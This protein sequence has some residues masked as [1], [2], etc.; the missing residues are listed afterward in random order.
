MFGVAMRRIR[1]RHQVGLLRARGHPGG[2]AAPLDIEEHRGDIG[3]VRESD[4]LLHERDAGARRVGE[5]TGTRP[6]GTDDDA[7]GGQFIFG[8]QNGVVVHA[9]LFVHAELLAECLELLH[10]RRGRR[11]GIPGAHGRAGI[12]RT[13]C[14]GR[15][16]IDEDRIAGGIHLLEME[17]QG[18][19]EVR[20][21]VV[22]AKPNGL[23]I[24]VEEF[25]L[26]AVLLGQHAAHHIHVNV[27]QRGECAGVHDV[28]QQGA[29]AIALEVLHAQAPERDAEDRDAL[30]HE[31]RLERP[32]RVVHEE[33]AGAH[34]GH[35][36]RIRGRI[37]RYHE[38]HFARARGVAV[39]A[40]ADFVPGG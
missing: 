29:V 38:I 36:L 17:G 31:V 33:P 26:L 3:V 25:G 21:G 35:V 6:A 1:E 23:V 19:L 11:D 2:G 12:D 18:A 7:G 28:A 15:V 14:A 9:G 4:E 8:L 10:Q 5:G 13:E 40:D 32:R 39:L 22:V 24:A 16:A 37:E 34:G 20:L 30:A 27:E